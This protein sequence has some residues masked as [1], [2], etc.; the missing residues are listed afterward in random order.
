MEMADDNKSRSFVAIRGVRIEKCAGTAGHQEFVA[1][2][3]KKT[4]MKM[5]SGVILLA[6]ASLSLG[7][8]LE[9]YPKERVAE[10]VVEKL[11]LNSLPDAIR[12]KR[13]KGKKTL[14]D[15]GYVARTIDQKGALLQEPL[16]RSQITIGVLEESKSGI[17]V[18]VNGQA[19]KEGNEQFQRVFLLKLKNADGL[20]KG[21]ESSKGFAGCPAIGGDESS[22]DA[23]GD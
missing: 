3:G 17:Y 13:E 16:G 14:A 2:A 15:Y 19:K 11:D 1:T 21:R 5:M 12:L 6:C 8:N 22:S 9:D 10:F 4:K 18:C 23:Y 20:L 7:K